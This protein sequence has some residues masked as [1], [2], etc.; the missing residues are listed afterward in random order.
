MSAEHSGN[1]MQAVT[2]D[3]LVKCD[4]LVCVSLNL[5]DEE[6]ILL[7]KRQIYG[8]NQWGCVDLKDVHYL[9]IEFLTKSDLANEYTENE[10]AKL[11]KD[12]SK[13]KC[14]SL[15]FWAYRTSS[16]CYMHKR[17][18]FA[19]GSN[20]SPLNVFNYD[21]VTYELCSIFSVFDTELKRRNVVKKPE[22]EIDW[23]YDSM[24]LESLYS[25]DEDDSDYDDY[26]TLYSASSSEEEE[27]EA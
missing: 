9:T 7:G 13:F 23:F 25:S 6:M 24:D 20:N 19:T 26:V 21:M 2:G 4:K 12:M 18:I 14:I 15:N 10:L 1:N 8:E 5:F 16:S 17:Y 11:V 22:Y 3:P 27:K